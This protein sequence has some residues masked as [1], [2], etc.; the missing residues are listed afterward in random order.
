MWPESKKRVANYTLKGAKFLGIDG[1]DPPC[2]QLIYFH[3]F[4][5]TE[6]NKSKTLEMIIFSIL[7]KNGKIWLLLE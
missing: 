4:M 1:Q 5:K 3:I 6:G 2:A 7:F